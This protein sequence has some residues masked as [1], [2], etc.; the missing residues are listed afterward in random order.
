VPV[1]IH[2]HY[3]GAMSQAFLYDFRRKAEPAILRPV[4]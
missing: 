3:N 2:G 4:D 1:S